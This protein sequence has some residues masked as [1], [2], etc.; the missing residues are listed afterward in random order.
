MPK[1]K[2]VFRLEI[3]PVY[4]KHHDGVAYINIHMDCSRINIYYM[5]TIS[6]FSNLEPVMTKIGNHYLNYAIKL[7]YPDNGLDDC[8]NWI[9]EFL[10]NGELHENATLADV[11]REI[12]EW[13][14]KKIYGEYS[15]WPKNTTSTA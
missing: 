7:G 2:N 10:N 13:M 14:K 12:F 11:Y 5:E 8:E 9:V 1:I 15:L 4:H 3:R 6:T